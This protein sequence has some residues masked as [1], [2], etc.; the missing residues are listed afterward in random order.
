[1]L[2]DWE[3]L[4]FM[5]GSAGAGLIG[6]LFVVVTLTAGFDQSRTAYGQKLYLTPT[7]F[8]FGVVLTMSA[9]A[10]APGLPDAGTATILAVVAL[11]GLAIAVRSYIGI[12]RPPPPGVETHWTDIWMY[13]VAPGAIYV[14]I[15]GA[16]V[17]LGLGL[18]L[19]LAELTM[20]ALLLALLLLS[21]RNAWDLVT[22]IAPRAKDLAK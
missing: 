17:L 21:I 22:W 14:G 18:G 3:T 4:Y 15:G 6:L 1:V 16:C 7:A 10:I 5:L 8:H 9:V 20:A 12:G 19:P 2:K 11:C 13:G